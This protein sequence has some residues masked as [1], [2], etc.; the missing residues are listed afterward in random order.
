MLVIERLQ[1]QWLSIGPDIR[2]KLVRTGRR[3]LLG[4]E[5]PPERLVARDDYR[6]PNRASTPPGQSNLTPPAEAA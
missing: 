3:T 2:I 4:I 5:A 1:G 6:G